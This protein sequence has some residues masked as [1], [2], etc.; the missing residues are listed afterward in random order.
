MTRR[1]LPDPLSVDE[2][3]R[4][5]AKL[6]SYAALTVEQKRRRLADVERRAQRDM[7][8]ARRKVER[9]EWHD[10]MDGVEVMTPACGDVLP[11]ERMYG[12]AR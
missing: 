1:P 12:G 8:Q 3:D 5:D 6:L 10:D 2:A 7:V 4:V 9:A 11:S